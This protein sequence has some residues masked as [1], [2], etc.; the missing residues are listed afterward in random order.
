MQ[1]QSDQDSSST[2]DSKVQKPEKSVS[3]TTFIQVFGPQEW[4][5]LDAHEA[6]AARVVQHA[7]AR[8]AH[9]RKLRADQERLRDILS[10]QSAAPQDIK[11][12]APSVPVIGTENSSS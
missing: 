5:A 12:T 11:E 1:I 4:A 2:T 6:Y 9:L 8:L 3:T 10:S 7:Q